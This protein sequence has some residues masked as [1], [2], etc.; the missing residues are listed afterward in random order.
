VPLLKIFLKERMDQGCE[1]VKQAIDA[2]SNSQTMHQADQWLI[3]FEK[4]YDAWKISESLLEE[5]NS[6]YRFFGAKFLYSK[7]SKQAIQLAASD[8]NSLVSRL[9]QKLFIYASETKLDTRT[10]RYVSLSISAL[11]L[12]MN[13][14][15]IIPQ[16]LTTMNSIATAHPR[17]LLCLL[18]VLPEEC[19]NNRI[20]V[21]Q[22][23]RKQFSNQLFHSSSE[24]IRYLGMLLSNPLSE[25]DLTALISCANN[26]M[27]LA[28]ADKV[29]SE[30]PS[31]VEFIIRTLLQISDND[32]LFDLCCDFIIIVV[33]RLSQKDTFLNQVI[34]VLS[35]L[36]QRW[37]QILQKVKSSHDDF[38]EDLRNHARSLSRFYTEIAEAAI[39]F[40]VSP[41]EN[42]WKTEFLTQLLEFAAF[43]HDHGVAR[44]PLKFF[45]DI[46]LVLRDHHPEDGELYEAGHNTL[47]HTEREKT[48]QNFKPVFQNLLQIAAESMMLMNSS[49]LLN[50]HLSSEKRDAR[51]E[52]RETILDCCDV[53]SGEQCLEQLC[54]SLETE[55]KSGAD[56]INWRKVESSILAMSFVV[57]TVQLE[58]K[59]FI[60]QLIGLIT[61]LPSDMSRLQLTSIEMLGELSRWFVFNPSYINAALE[62]LFLDIR[63]FPLCEAAARSIMFIFKECGKLN[64]LP[65]K[66]CHDQ[67]VFLLHQ[68]N[69]GETAVHESLFCLLEGLMVALSS[70]PESAAEV[71]FKEIL[72]YQVNF[73]REIVGNHPNSP[74]LSLIRSLDRIA[75]VYKH[76]IRHDK[77]LVP[78]FTELFP[79]LKSV[80]TG[81]LRESICEKVCRIY[82]FAIKACGI[83]FG[84][85]LPGFLENLS[86]QFQTLPVSAFLY[87][88]SV[89]VSTFAHVEKEKFDWVLYQFLWNVSHTFFLKFPQIE[90]HKK[91]PDV[92][93]EYY[94]LVGKYLQYS[95]KFFAESP[96]ESTLIIKLA[97]DAATKINHREAQKGI[98]MFFQRLVNLPSFW[99]DNSPDNLKSHQLNQDF[100]PL[101][102]ITFVLMLSG[103]I[104]VYAIDEKDGCVAD[105]FWDIRKLYPNSFQVFIFSFF[106]FP[107][108]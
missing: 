7:A 83:S 61:K 63:N 90:D 31:L 72:G 36:K 64:S 69:S 75:L 34:S 20:L 24:I 79:I 23:V 43:R 51:A 101:I 2:L 45:Y 18:T 14:D 107:T 95:P 84:D 59:N 1:Q 6:T 57:P 27:S 44:I 70:Y 98:L 46:S 88:G 38:D 19:S 25:E 108:F 22:Q 68:Q 8:I 32:E 16:L 48:H 17:I 106:R 49:D 11:V 9:V 73:L 91:E 92:L 74:D 78:T 33:R 52:W 50:T 85:C 13:I 10:V 105:V 102:I 47:S 37:L 12:Q 104:P 41:Q 82:K 35:Q 87:V 58:G 4:T 39:P 99:R 67:V 94:Y 60:P 71:F 65:I 103:S 26:W 42:A 96:T 21:S 3:S 56:S 66:E 76:Y 30:T 29:L 89:C 77:F 100:C 62:K 93:E 28:D 53:L 97:L 55:F 5:K 80:L 86:Q 81:F 40:F 15:G 54:S